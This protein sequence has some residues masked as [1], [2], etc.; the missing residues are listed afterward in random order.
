MIP[1]YKLWLNGLYW[2]W[3][4]RNAVE[5]NRSLTVSDSLRER[6][7]YFIH[8]FVR[9]AEQL[10][11]LWIMS[12]KQV[13]GFIYISAWIL[14]KCQTNAVKLHYTHSNL[15]EVPPAPLALY[16]HELGLRYN[17]ITD[18]KPPSLMD[19]PDLQKLDLAENPLSIIHNGAF[20]MLYQLQTLY[21]GHTDITHLPSGFGPITTTL[22]KIGCW[23]AI[24]NL[25]VIQFP[26]FVAFLNLNIINIGASKLDIKNASI[27]PASIENINIRDTDITAFPQLSKYMPDV[28]YV[29]IGQNQLITIPQED[30]Q[31]LTLLKKFNAWA[32][33]ITS[34]PNF[35]HCVALETLDLDENKIDDIPRGHIFGLASIK[36]IS[37]NYNVISVMLDTSQLSTL[38]T[39]KIG[40]NQILQIPEEYISGLPNMKVFDCQGNQI[41]FL[42]NISK[43]FP[44][45]QELYV[46]GNHMMS[47]PDLYETTSLGLLYAADNP[48]VCNQSL[49]WLRMLAWV[50][51]SMT[52]L[53][54]QPTCQEPHL[55]AGTQVVRY[56]PATMGCYEGRITKIPRA[57][58]VT[59]VMMQPDANY[60]STAFFNFL[61]RSLFRVYCTTSAMCRESKEDIYH[62]ETTQHSKS[63]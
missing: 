39:F 27:F 3:C 25:E 10:A 48:Y 11:S 41:T 28:M 38:E 59:D 49:C 40:F 7:T 18:L 16:V 32:N 30:I 57:L 50:R 45:I 26:Y 17:M 20:D 4:P 61:K 13:F 56:H 23:R 8:D 6:Y 53:Q 22:T 43:L 42:P 12:R 9:F 44:Q 19:Y 34:F 15:T 58:Y 35:S 46:Q 51:P 21:L 60:H 31:G 54:D 29:Q 47:L 37:F 55:A 62:C 52:M 24:K 1:L 36:Y 2:P 5:L 14:F 63:Q 33:Q